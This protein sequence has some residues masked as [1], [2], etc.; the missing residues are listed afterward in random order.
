MSPIRP[1]ARRAA[2]A[3]AALLALASVAGCASSSDAPYTI[4]DT[5]V[6]SADSGMTA[7]F[8]LLTNTTDDP[9]TIVSATS[10]V[11]SKVELHEVVM[12]D[13]GAMVMQPK[14]GG[15][16]IGPHET[17][18]LEPGGFHIMLMGVKQPIVAGDDVEITLT[19]D[20]GSTL[21]FHA[22]AKD[23]AGA[24][25]NYTGGVAASPSPSAAA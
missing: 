1:V 16:E 11:A 4:T 7:A 13:G 2:A 10:P 17:L 8:G 18:T 6:K 21:T 22:I 9:V 3:I 19:M 5:W 14:P 12:G 23:F 25:E 20:D 24:N 15:F